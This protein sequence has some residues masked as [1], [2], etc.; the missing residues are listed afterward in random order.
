MTAQATLR[1][2][3]IPWLAAAVPPTRPPTAGIPRLFVVDD[4]EL[5]CRHLQRVGRQLNISVRT[6]HPD[7]D[8]GRLPEDG[9]FDAAIIDYDLG[10]LLGTQLSV[11][12][13]ETPVLLVSIKD[14]SR[15]FEGWPQSVRG[16]V[17]K[18][19]GAESILYAA[20]DLGDAAE[21]ER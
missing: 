19:Q 13:N 4:D 20:V 8:F 7:E 16:F 12:Y 18:Q 9:D 1:P 15:R 17:K 2:L 10:V 5:F 6:F 3:A 14:R 21:S 11:L